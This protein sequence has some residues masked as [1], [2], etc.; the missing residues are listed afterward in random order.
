MDFK[1][2]FNYAISFPSAR[3]LATTTMTSKIATQAKSYAVSI[4]SIYMYMD[5]IIFVRAKVH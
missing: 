3:V 1:S 2:H 4:Y 5:L